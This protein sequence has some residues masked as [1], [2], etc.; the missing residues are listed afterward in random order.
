MEFYTAY[1]KESERG[2]PI[3]R[4]V[5]ER[6]LQ[7]G[8]LNTPVSNFFTS[9]VWLPSDAEGVVILGYWR[10]GCPRILKMWLARDMAALGSWRC[11]YHRILD[12][13]VGYTR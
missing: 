10:C 1:L 7:K 9:L 3:I 11:D 8:K 6:T 5:T 13:F 12:E 4:R 2:K